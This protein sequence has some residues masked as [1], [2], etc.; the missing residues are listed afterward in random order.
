MST[1]EATPS[2]P[3]SPQSATRQVCE[4]PP[5]PP[6]T[7]PMDQCAKRRWSLKR[8][9][10]GEAS[11]ASTDSLRVVC[12]GRGGVLPLHL[13]LRPGATLSSSTHMKNAR[14]SR[15]SSP[16]LSPGRSD[17]ALKALVFRARGGQALARRLQPDVLQTLETLAAL[18]GTTVEALVSE[19]EL[20]VDQVRSDGKLVDTPR[21]RVYSAGLRLVCRHKKEE[22]TRDSRPRVRTTGT[23]S[24]REAGGRGAD[25][26]GRQPLH[27]GAAAGGGVPHAGGTQR[28]QP[29]HGP[30]LRRRGGHA[31][32]CA[33][34]ARAAAQVDHVSRLRSLLHAWCVP[35]SPAGSP[36]LGSLVGRLSRN[37]VDS[38]AA[39]N[40]SEMRFR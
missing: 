31:E 23:L 19:M 27:A 20:N 36:P 40:G 25:E 5:A 10:G 32:A 21:H 2:R 29:H 1:S 15:P 12:C 18:D 14:I 37:T 6:I 3:S 17:C 26:G 16:L 24:C 39:A 35:R 33:R 30:A 9:F 38:R 13:D 34:R 4:A 11:R 7:Q 8:R 22:A 28:H